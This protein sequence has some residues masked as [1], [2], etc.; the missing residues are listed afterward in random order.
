MR[1]SGPAVPQ[2]GDSRTVLGFPISD[3]AALFCAPATT[4]DMDT[5][6]PP[7]RRR[8]RLPAIATLAFLVV[9]T[10]LA[11]WQFAESHSRDRCLSDL[12]ASGVLLTSVTTI[13]NWSSDWPFHNVTRVT[14]ITLVD[15]LFKNEDVRRLR[16]AFPDVE[17]YRIVPG[18]GRAFKA[19][20]L[21]PE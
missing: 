16:R 15:G 6:Q 2:S 12:K 5:P 7:R 11:A 8:F 21:A 4:A 14:A 10:C 13:D 18:S 20:P 17:I 9:V 1:Q 3:Y 19:E